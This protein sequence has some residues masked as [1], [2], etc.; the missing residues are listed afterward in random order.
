VT[1]AHPE[2]PWREMRDMRNEV[3]PVHFGIKTDVLW[4]TIQNDLPPLV[5]LLR[6]LLKTDAQDR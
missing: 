3:I 1:K 6:N 4:G 5:P 2:I